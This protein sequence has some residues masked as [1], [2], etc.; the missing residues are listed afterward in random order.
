MAPMPAAAARLLR[1]LAPHALVALAFLA[2]SLV[3]WWG[4]WTGHPTS[5]ATC[6]CADQALLSWFLAWPPYALAHGQNPLFSTALAHPGGVNLAANTSVLLVGTLLAPVTWAFGPVATLGLASTLAPVASGLGAY[7]LLRRW[8]T[9]GPAAFAGGLLYGFSPVVLDGLAFEHIDVT[10]LVL[11]PLI[12]LCLDELL[13]RQQGRTWTWG[14]ALGLAVTGQ[15]FVSSEVLTMALLLGVL[16]LALHLGATALADPAALRARLPHA[17]RGLALAGAL[18]ALLLAYP[19]WFALAGPQHLQAQAQPLIQYDGTTLRSLLLPNPP[20][21]RGPNPTLL[22]QG[23]PGALP[24]GPGYL[25]PGLLAVLALGTL[26]WRRDRRLLLLAALLLLTAALSL[27]VPLPPGPGR[28]GGT[29]SWRPWQLLDHLPLL[30]SIVPARL[31]VLTDLWAALILG[32][33]L[34]HARALPAT[35]LPG[36][37]PRGPQL[38]ALATALLALGPLWALTD[39]PLRTGPVA[40]PAWFTGPEAR[41][42]SS[43]VLLVYPYPSAASQDPILWQAQAGPRIALAGRGGITPAPTGPD[44]PSRRT[45]ETTDA[46]LTNLTFGFGPL[47]EG[48]PSE[49]AGLRQALTTWGV[50]AVVVPGPVPGAPGLPPRSLS[51]ALGLLTAAMGRPPVAQAGAALWTVT[52]DTDPPLTLPPGTLAGCTTAGTAPP[53]PSTVA[54]CVLAAAGRS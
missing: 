23:Y 2:L 41:L 29:A 22:Q 27:G 12:L 34:D 51:W 25:G 47:P 13:V 35:A 16:G 49:L 14:L 36:R 5:T 38:L 32:L 9:W 17:L 1:R 45:A 28:S 19:A 50:T 18:A 43:T 42:P 11:P 26:L 20:S 39:L 53:D 7:A 44:S 31:P 48:S 21:L 54:G 6:G 4:F 40:V 52:D 30:R 37:H 10:I 8:T 15:F 3:L 24:L 33:V 46:L